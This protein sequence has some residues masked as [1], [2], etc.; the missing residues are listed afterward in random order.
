MILRLSPAGNYEQLPGMNATRFTF[1]LLVAVLA[2]V[3]GCV[4]KPRSNPLEG[5]KLSWSHDPNQLNKAISD[6]YQNYIQKLPPQE[7]AR[8][9]ESNIWFLE[10]LTGQHAVKIS[11]PL[12]GFWSGIWWDHILI[13]DRNNKRIKT[14]KY[15]S[16]RYLS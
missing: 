3:T 2:S 13:Y 10:D 4:T 5:W 9:I 15:K 8:V 7:R 1:C 6:D 12:E 16:G 14:I 11:I